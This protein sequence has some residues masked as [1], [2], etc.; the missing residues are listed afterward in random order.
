MLQDLLIKLWFVLLIL[1]VSLGPTTPLL[2]EESKATKE[3]DHFPFPVKVDSEAGQTDGLPN[4]VQNPSSGMWYALVPAG[5]YTIGSDQIQ[6]SKEIQVQLSPF[7]ISETCVTH[8]Q[9]RQELLTRLQ[10][11]PEGKEVEERL[12]LIH[13][14]PAA[15]QADFQLG[16]MMLNYYI[17]RRDWEDL[18][19]L[20]PEIDREFA[21]TSKEVLE[22][23]HAHENLS[24]E[25]QV[26]QFQFTSPQRK[27]FNKVKAAII[28]CLQ[29]AEKNGFPYQRATHRNAV[30]YAE[31]RGVALPTEAQWEVAARLSAAGKLHVDP[32]VRNHREYCSDFY[33][34]DY[35]QRK[36]HFKDPTGPRRG[37]FSDEQ[38]ERETQVA[39]LK[40][41]TRIV[42]LNAVVIRGESISKREYSLAHSNS[43]ESR[44]IRLVINPN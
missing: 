34:F 33:A 14:L 1:G 8:G 3:A 31:W 44:R 5:T 29:H 23:L 17:Y 19:Q 27:S 32:L 42:A 30:T 16:N 12:S 37:K 24:M 18:N 41:I 4:R 6:D 20:D 26:K 10:M 43:N 9:V 40:V 35:F 21:V 7:Y 2:A 28:K 11:Y 39:S 38:L 13:Q 15:R 36:K 25:E 22:Q